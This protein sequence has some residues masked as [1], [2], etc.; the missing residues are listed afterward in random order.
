MEPELAEGRDFTPFVGGYRP[1]ACRSPLGY[2]SN[3]AHPGLQQAVV[4]RTQLSL[5]HLSR[6]R[7]RDRERQPTGDVAELMAELEP[8]V[9]RQRHREAQPPLAHEA[10]HRVRGI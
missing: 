8:G 9:G 5:R 1:F 4:D 3:R 10:A 2:S 7:E 6:G